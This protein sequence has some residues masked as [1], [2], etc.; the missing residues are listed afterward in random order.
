MLTGGGLTMAHKDHQ[1][2]DARR[3]LL[4]QLPDADQSAL[5]LRLLTEDDTFAELEIVEVELI[6]EYLANELSPDERQR[7]EE[8][9]L[10]TPDRENKLTTA[11]ALKRY[12]KNIA[13]PDPQPTSG[14]FG[15]W[16]K[17]LRQLISSP[18]PAAVSAL[19]LVVIGLALWRL[20]FYQSDLDKG[21]VALNKA[22]R[23]E[24]PIEARVSQLDYAPYDTTR[25]NESRP[26]NILE[27][28][29]AQVYLLQA[30]QDRHDAAAY[31]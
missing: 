8:H 7:F 13:P 29:R 17:A 26:V 28:S 15:R 3:Y 5:E 22:F 23:Q 1:Q 19:F 31:H 27:L 6:D 14:K 9:F 16:L 21:M 25:G 10:T 24:R 18:I 4:K 30:E 20:V 2:S 11:Q 12:L